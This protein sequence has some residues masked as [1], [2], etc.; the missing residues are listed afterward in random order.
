MTLSLIMGGRSLKLLYA[1]F[2][3]L[4]HLKLALGFISGVGDGNVWCVERERQALL[5][6]QKGL[7]DDNNR[8][9]SW[10]SEYA[11][12]N[13]CSWEGVQCSYQT[14]H[15]LK[16]D[17][18]AE[19]NPT[20]RGKISPS[21]IELH[22]L[23][24][25]SLSSNDFNQS[26]FPKFIT[27]LTNLK[28]LDL[29]SANLTGPIPSHLGNLT[30]LQYL[31]LSW[32]HFE[33]IENLEWLSH[34]VSIRYLDL[35][36]LNLNVTND[37]LKVVS[38]LPKLS[39]LWLTNCDLP[40]ITSSS[41][42][43]INSTKSLTFLDLSGNPRI[44]SSIF[45]WLYN[46]STNLASLDLSSNQLQGSIPNAFGN[47][48]SLEQLTLSDN[49]L[50]G[51]IPKSFGDIC[52]LSILDLS[53]NNLD[54]Q[55][56]EFFHNL[57]GCLKD[58]LRELYLSNNKL[59][60]TLGKRIESLNKLEVLSVR[61]NML[62]GVISEAQL[63]NFPKL[64]YLDLSYNSFTLNISFDWV[65]PFQLGYLYLRSCKLGPD[66]PNWIK[67]QRNLSLLDVSSNKISNTIPTWFWDTPSTLQYLNLSSNQIKGRLP[68][69][70]TKFRSLTLLD[71]S[72]NRFEGP[73]PIISSNLT[74]LNLSK[75]KFSGL[76][77]FM[78]SITGGM[79][80]LLD[81]SSNH[82]SEEISD[83]I[84][85]WQ[86]VEFLNL[87]HN[88]LSG[89]IPSSLGSLTRLKTLELS[90]NSFSGELP[91]SL[92]NC[93]MLRFMLLQENTL[94][95]K[96]P[97]WIGERMSSLIILSLR[98]NKFHG[99]IPLQICLL[100]QIQFLD[101]SHNSIS[102]NIPECLNNLTTMVHKVSY[103]L[104]G[105]YLV[106]YDIE[107]V[108]GYRYL[109]YRKDGINIIVGWKGN[110][111]SIDFAN[112]KLT[113]NIPEEISSLIELKALNLSGNML[114]GRIPQK[115]GQLEQLESLD[116][117]RNKFFGSIPASMANLH[118]LGYLDLSYNEFSGKIPTGTQLQSFS[119]L[120]FIGNL[121]LCGP[122]LI[123]K[124][125][126][127]VTSNTTTNSRSKSYQED[128]D[129]FWKCLYVGMG[130]GFFV[131]FWGVCG[132]LILNRSWRHAYF[133]LLIYLKDWLYVTTVVY[134]ARL[135]KMFH[136]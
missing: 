16:L 44:T 14:G 57:R 67:T 38:C 34:L 97:T 52:T 29:F 102:G 92:Q 56:L 122:P 119:P 70:F 68:N 33:I 51:H 118:Y 23:S 64:Y 41:L 30:R 24:Y 91:W 104:S 71:L 85:H 130:L 96:I 28:H 121:G 80:R 78:C 36:Y 11:K 81:L 8:L 90:N 35:S 95:G 115:I 62:E 107:Y 49:Q 134:I 43:H 46:S 48:N 26:Q 114:T 133:L 61:S 65:P 18:Q 125:P 120:K 86:E 117:S 124:C 105:Y 10:G 42:S 45:P 127:D 50:E 25:L 83:C 82:L 6:F 12:K 55:V 89:E 93:T 132:S 103:F 58:S 9:S 131:G 72:S 66:F 20:L 69:I 32:N 27:S 40:L 88:N 75:N 111:R 101:L 109:F 126:G 1:I 59:N 129:E 13:C 84:K 39:V 5:E 2:T 135:Q 87:A 22:H 106:W 15:V 74:S 136:S 19:D 113:G 79:L 47:M 63:S 31:D 94:S 37:W 98:S 76:N 116:L 60:G 112:N 21:L 110:M 7:I 123:E 99:S 3:L 108:S 17:L 4:M 53:T 100:V 73:L 77:S 128:G 54:G